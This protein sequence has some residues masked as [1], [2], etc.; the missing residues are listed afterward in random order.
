MEGLAK[1]LSHADPKVLT[2]VT[3]GIA[4]LAVDSIAREKVGCLQYNYYTIIEPLILSYI[5]FRLIVLVLY[6]NSCYQLTVMC[7]VIP[8]G[9]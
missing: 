2:N 9:H 6:Y 1:C 8:P 5:S 3:H 4:L 7:V